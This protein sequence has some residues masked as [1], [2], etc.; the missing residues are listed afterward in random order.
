MHQLRKPS[1]Q[2]I[3]YQAAAKEGGLNTGLGFGLGSVARDAGAVSTIDVVPL[4]ERHLIFEMTLRF[5][6][7]DP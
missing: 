7:N 5:C 2:G 4:F 1:Y 6:W 3:T